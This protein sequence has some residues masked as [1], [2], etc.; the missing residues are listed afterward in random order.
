MCVCVCM[1]VWSL[2]LFTPH[3]SL[4]LFIHTLKIRGEGGL[5]ILLSLYTFLYNFIVKKI[6]MYVETKSNIDMKGLTE[7]IKELDLVY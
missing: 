1:H 3:L 6:Y 5:S 2:S 7:D 4:P